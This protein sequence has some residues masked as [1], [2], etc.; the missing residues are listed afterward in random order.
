MKDLFKFLAGAIYP[1]LIMGFLFVFASSFPKYD[2]N[3]ITEVCFFG[4]LIFSVIFV[5]GAVGYVI[6][7]FRDIGKNKNP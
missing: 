3:G 1:A 6:T 4:V 5:V 7:L 2:Y